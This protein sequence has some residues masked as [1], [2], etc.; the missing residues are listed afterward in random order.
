ML[1]DAPVGRLG[2]AAGYDEAN[3]RLIVFGGM[4]G[5]AGTDRNDT[6][7]M[8]ED[9]NGGAV[10][11]QLSPQGTP[12][13]ARSLMAYYYNASSNEL[14][15]FG[16]YT[17]VQ[18]PTN[19]IFYNDVWVLSHA[20]GLGGTSAWTQVVPSGGPPSER[21]LA[22]IVFDG[23][24]D[25][26]LMF[27]GYIYSSDGN[28]LG[29]LWVLNHPAGANGPPQWL[30]VSP[31]GAAPAPRLG[32]VAAY[33]PSTDRMIVTSG[34]TEPANTYPGDTWVFQGGRLVQ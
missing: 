25:R 8:T 16:G 2:L 27:G 4:Q 34:Y 28:A 6:W 30:N 12:P 17:Y 22:T 32:H 18:A 33:A 3:R 9:T 31:A 10:W 14:V 1:P 24:S 29:D 7:V 26:A 13:A 21:S 15:I 20:N 11:S 5:Y 19:Y 23:V